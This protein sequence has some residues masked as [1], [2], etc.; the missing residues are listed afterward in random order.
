MRRQLIRLSHDTAMY[1]IGRDGETDVPLTRG[2]RMASVYILPPSLSHQ[3]GHDGSKIHA[4]LST[5]VAVAILTAVGRC[6]IRRTSQTSS[7]TF[8]CDPSKHK[9][10]TTTSLN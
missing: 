4:M 8:C 6:F 7:M 9:Y 3:R 2:V 10:C 1:K 5:Y